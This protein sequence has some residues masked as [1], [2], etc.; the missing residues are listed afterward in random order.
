MKSLAR[1]GAMGGVGGA[2]DKFVAFPV[3]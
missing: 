1:V 2:L 3:R